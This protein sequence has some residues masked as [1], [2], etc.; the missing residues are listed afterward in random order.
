MNPLGQPEQL[1]VVAPGDQGAG[2]ALS[3][4]HEAG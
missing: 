4:G 1:F 3:R 2:E